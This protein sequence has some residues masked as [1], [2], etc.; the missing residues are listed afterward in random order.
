MPSAG[1]ARTT[2]TPGRGVGER[3]GG[4]EERGRGRG[5]KGGVGIRAAETGSSAEVAA[6]VAA[7]AVSAASLARAVLARR[8]KQAS[9]PA[10]ILRSAIPGKA[11]E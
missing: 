7:S 1:V 11:E 4:R 5:E 6:D 3:N 2:G 10:A 9:L 8:K